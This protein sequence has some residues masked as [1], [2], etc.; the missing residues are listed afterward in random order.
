MKTETRQAV[1]ECDARNCNGA[2]ITNGDMPEGW[3]RVHVDKINGVHIGNAKHVCPRCAQKIL[4]KLCLG[5]YKN[6][7]KQ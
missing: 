3:I 6:S 4:R 5:P 1:Y 7:G 2:S